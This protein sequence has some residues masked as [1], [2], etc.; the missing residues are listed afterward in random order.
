MENILHI[1]FFLF[2]LL[3]VGISENGQDHKSCSVNY[4]LVSEIPEIME[5]GDAQSDYEDGIN[6]TSLTST[7]LPGHMTVTDTH[8]QFSHNKVCKIFQPPR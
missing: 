1:V 6:L 5:K 7:L 2:V 3:S 4:S 8:E